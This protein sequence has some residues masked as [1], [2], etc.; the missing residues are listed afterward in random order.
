MLQTFGKHIWPRGP[1][2][3]RVKA[4][5]GTALV[6]MVSA[7]LAN[8]QVPF[9]FK[10]IVDGLTVAP[11]T[12]AA[13]VSATLGVPVALVLGYGIARIS[14]L[15]FQEA[16]NVVFA[17]V[18]Q[19][20]IRKIGRQTFEHLHSLD[21]QFHLAR[22]TGVVSRTLDRG[23]R[24]IDFVLRSIVF[25]VVPTTLE[26]AL[27]SGILANQCGLQYAVV[28]L[29]T[30]VT[31]TA[32][33][34]SVTQ[35]RT[36]FRREMIKNENEA[37]NQV[38]ESLVNYE[39]VKYF[40]NEE[41]ESRKYDEVLRRCERSS[42]EAQ[43]S[44]SFLNLG[45]NV[46]FTGGL[47]AMMYMASGAIVEGSMT[48]GDLVLVNGLLFQLSIPLNFIGSLYRELRQALVDM[49]AMFELRSATGRIADRPGCVTLDPSDWR[50]RPLS[51]GFDGVEFAY[52]PQQRRTL[53]GVS[54]S[55]PAGQTVA[56]V[57]TSGCG[58]STLIRLLYRFYDVQAGRITLDGR[59]IRDISLASLRR[60]IAVVPQDTVLFNDTIFRNIAY[61]KPG[62]P[63]LA[64]AEEVVA[65]AKAAQIHAAILA[66][67]EGYDT[68]VGE[69]GMK[70]SG[71]EKQ[72][73]SIARALLK[74]A[75]ILVCDE[76][77]SSLDT[78]TEV[79]IM[80]NL[81]ALGQGRTMCLIA[82]RLSTVQDANLIVVLEDGEIVEA[83]THEQ[84]LQNKD[85]GS[86]SHAGR[87]AE[88]WHMQA[89]AA[90]DAGAD[91]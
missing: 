46:I 49:E 26:I 59:D 53:S 89:A 64:T 11:G 42:L 34:V 7:K 1:D 40:G 78:E 29:G 25:T 17:S 20:A 65:A 8:I 62:G 71:G 73:V 72:R 84:L 57:G 5:V 27:V 45:Q 4:R 48:V 74:D 63:D 6:L 22:Q 55:V 13:T 80:A 19:T 38:L 23:A 76:A 35:W 31:Y 30:L 10:A 51:I 61:G 15:F 2:S 81:K 33:T 50:E 9:L 24:S 52:P 56:F 90:A 47:T 41:H 83:G 54:C 67:P 44:L 60:A 86:G 36:K 75:P 3:W 39:T 32:F 79:E 82:H 70:L 21:L 69:R 28:T 77:T 85:V 66:L 12:D 37:S 58:K 43:S 16:R 91:P 87:Y 68:V 88:L 14:V 18:A